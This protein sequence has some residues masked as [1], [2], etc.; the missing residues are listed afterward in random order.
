M[1]YL[2]CFSVSAHASTETSYPSSCLKQSNMDATSTPWTT[3][4]QEFNGILKNYDEMGNR[5]HKFQI[6]RLWMPASRFPRYPYPLELC[7]HGK[8]VWACETMRFDQRLIAIFPRKLL[9][10]RAQTLEKEKSVSEAALRCKERE[11]V[12][13]AGK[14][15]LSIHTVAV[16]LSTVS[17][18]DE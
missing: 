8:I 1:L 10:A 14:S 17:K 2:A 11:Q 18:I 5:E 13:Y 9:T 4:R 15:W 3:N 16:N 12:E 7:K 6:R